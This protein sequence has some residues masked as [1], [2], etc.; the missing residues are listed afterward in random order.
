MIR[1]IELDVT[2]G[3][4]EE[5]PKIYAI[6]FYLKFRQTPAIL[7]VSTD[8]TIRQLTYNLVDFIKVIMTLDD[9]Q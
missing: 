3:A 7:W 6:K 1:K 8:I 4:V 9:A 5:A 2:H